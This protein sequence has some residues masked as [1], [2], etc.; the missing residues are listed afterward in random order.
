VKSVKTKE[1]GMNM[2]D[3]DGLW[4]MAAALVFGVSLIVWAVSGSLETTVMAMVAR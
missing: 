4:I 1:K 3:I 2:K